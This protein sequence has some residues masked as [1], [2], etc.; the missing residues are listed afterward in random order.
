MRLRHRLAGQFSVARVNS[1]NQRR[2][3][4][5]CTFEAEIGEQLNIT[6]SD[7][8][9]RLRGRARVSRGHV[10]HAVVRDAFFDIN[11]IDMCGRSRSFRAAALINGNI[12]EHAAGFH[13]F[14]HR[15]RDQFR[16]LCSR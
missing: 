10:C 5:A 9:E 11:W 3:R 6:I 13:L 7:V 4:L 15:A 16:G 12:D 8:G 1:A 2:L 14:Q